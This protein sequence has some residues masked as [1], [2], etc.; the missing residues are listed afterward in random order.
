VW[1]WFGLKLY[2]FDDHEFKEV[3]LTFIYTI[4]QI[5]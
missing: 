1:F 2:L 5:Q 3:E 4:S